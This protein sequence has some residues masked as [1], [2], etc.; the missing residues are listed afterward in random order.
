M[1]SV[2]IAT[3]NGEKYIAQQIQ[4]IVPQLSPQD[5]IIISD[6]ES[7]D[8]TLNVVRALGLSQIRIFRHKG[9]RGYVSNFEHALSKSKGDVIFLCDQDDIWLPHKVATCLEALKEADLVVSDAKLIDAEEHVIGE[10]FYALR[11]PHKGFAG[12][13]LKFGYIGCCMCFKRKVLQAALPFPKNRRMCTHDNWLFMVAS[14]F[15]KTRVLTEPL[16]LYRRHHDNASNGFRKGHSKWNFKVAYRFYLL[17]MLSRRA[18]RH[19]SKKK[20]KH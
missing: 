3:Y 11:R 1:I 7:D 14:A 18:A 10:S 5:E 8:S 17:Y 19:N 12:N 13:S 6:D 20:K 9:E 4:S 16:I 2:C 15:F